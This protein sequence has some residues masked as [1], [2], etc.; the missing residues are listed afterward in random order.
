V[1]EDRIAWLARSTSAA[2]IEF[3]LRQAEAC[4]ALGCSPCRDDV[5]GYREALRRVLERYG[6]PRTADRRKR[7][8]DGKEGEQDGS[9]AGGA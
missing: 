9:Q 2:L 5:P 6:Q 7:R 4:A 8:Q 1:N 3:E